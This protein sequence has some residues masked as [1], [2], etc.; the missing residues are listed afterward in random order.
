MGSHAFARLRESLSP[1]AQAE[2]VALT[3]QMD[4]ELSLAEL[5]KARSLTQDQLAA[6]LH[7]GQ[8]SIAKLERRTDMYLSTLRRFVEAM[9]G[10]LEIVARFPDQPLVRLRGLGELAEEEVAEAG[11]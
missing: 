3:D 9:G 7:V 4:R 1:E 11:E 2:A 10:E 8:A 5:R 6:D